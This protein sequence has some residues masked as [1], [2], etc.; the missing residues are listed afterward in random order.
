MIILLCAS[1]CGCSFTAGVAGDR[2]SGAPRSAIYSLA[3]SGGR[4]TGEGE[5][6]RLELDGVPP[7]IARYVMRPNRDSF[8][9]R[10]ARFMSDWTKLFPDGEACAALSIDSE[11][12]EPATVMV[13]SDPRYPESGAGAASGTVSWA[14]SPLDQGM[15]ASGQ[16]DTVAETGGYNMPW[17]GRPLESLPRD[18]PA[19]TLFI[20]RDTGDGQAAPIFVEDGA[21]SMSFRGPCYYVNVDATRGVADEELGRQYARAM[22][23]I[24]RDAEFRVSLYVNTMLFMLATV[25]D[26]PGS[27]VLE[28]VEQV[29]ANMPEEYVRQVDGLASGMR[30]YFPLSA[31]SLIWLYNL[32]SDV[33]R[34]SKCSAYGVWGASSSTGS[35]VLYRTLDWYEGMFDEITEIQAVTRYHFADRDVHMIGALGHLGC[36]TGIATKDLLGRDGV[37]GAIMDANVTGSEYSARGCRSYN[38]DL[39]YALERL[40]SKD[41][42]SAFLADKPYTFSNVILLGD[43]ASTT[44]L[45]NNV[46]GRGEA[47]S[48]AVRTD[49]SPLIPGIEWGYPSMI[50]A[51]NA[52]CLRGQVNN[53]SRGENSEINVE[54]WDLLRKKIDELRRPDGTYQVTPGDVKAIMS[55]HRG[56][57]P[58]NFMKG[59]GDLYNQQT[60]QMMVY[61]PSAGSL[62]V[63]FKP[64]DGS[65]PV[66]PPTVPVPLKRM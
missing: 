19:S 62:D 29:K 66:P 51:V 53:F 50:G 54:R 41:E 5:G 1:A 33:F 24:N 14:V 52:F 8:T 40:D 36:I 9:E 32:M 63:F 42:I 17:R 57:V 4:L 58:G 65:T 59:E 16:G 31:D 6:L 26:I 22:N 35:N 15:T 34:W 28:R 60:Q 47:P 56:G 7:T 48:R 61:V 2:D 18:V 64:L 55:S 39:R 46:S 30:S 10:V 20:E 38:F 37:M 27:E 49:S 25:Y 21:V 43:S 44:V 3:S 45:E 13:L 12:G 11:A 23:A